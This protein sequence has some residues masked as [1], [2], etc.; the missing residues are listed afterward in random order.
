MVGASASFYIFPGKVFGE[1]LWEEKDAL[2]IWWQIVWD[3]ATPASKHK[4]IRKACSPG[5]PLAF[6]SSP[7][8]TV[9]AVK[10]AP[11]LPLRV[12]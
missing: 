10:A 4:K 9:L 6:P 2:L 12:S 5:W 8:G 3:Y 1:K 11:V 7:G